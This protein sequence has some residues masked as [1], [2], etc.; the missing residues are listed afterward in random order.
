MKVRTV[1][2]IQNKFHFLLYLKYSI[3]IVDF[4][5]DHHCTFKAETKWTNK[6]KKQAHCHLMRLYLCVSF[7]QF[8]MSH[9]L[10]LLNRLTMKLKH[11]YITMTPD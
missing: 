8:V 3:F 4:I 1:K 10:E 7:T 9:N 2:V 6:K 5:I 11:V